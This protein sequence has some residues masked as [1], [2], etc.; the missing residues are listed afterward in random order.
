MN[1][2]IKIILI[3]RSMC[4]KTTMTQF[5]TNEEIKYHKTQT[6]QIVNHNMID[7]PGEYIERRYFR[8]AL[9]VTSADADVI[10]LVQA[11]NEGG[12]MFPPAY[13]ANYAKPCIGVVTK[14]DLAQSEEDIENAKAFLRLAGAKDIF[15]TS[16]YDG[17]GFEGFIEWL[18]RYEEEKEK[19]EAAKKK[20]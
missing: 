9:M 16:S 19:K 8:G 12:T 17:T 18:D 4:G 14:A 7:T 15:V 6:V 1:D 5:L 10:V 20:K 11:A 13:A 2:K 3:G